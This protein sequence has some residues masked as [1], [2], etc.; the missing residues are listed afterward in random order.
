MVKIAHLIV[1]LNLPLYWNIIVRHFIQKSEHLK[2]QY[3]R[4]YLFSGLLHMYVISPDD[5]ISLFF[6]RRLPLHMNCCRIDGLDFDVL[7]VSRN[8]RQTQTSLSLNLKLVTICT[9]LA[10]FLVVLI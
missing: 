7:W 9:K 10:H 4:A 6:D 8:Y 1:Y 3:K 2:N 5:S